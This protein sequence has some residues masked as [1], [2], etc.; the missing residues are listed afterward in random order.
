MALDML[1]LLFLN[2]TKDAHPFIEQQTVPIAILF[3]NV[4]PAIRS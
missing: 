1:A 4:L 3:A 2:S